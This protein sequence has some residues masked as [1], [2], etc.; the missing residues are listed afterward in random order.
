M[1]LQ[2]KVQIVKARQ[3]L[4]KYSQTIDPSSCTPL[5]RDVFD[6][7]DDDSMLQ[8][9]AEEKLDHFTKLV[10]NFKESIDLSE[11][12]DPVLNNKLQD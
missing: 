8:Y 7:Y 1:I 11:T 6:N 12:F 3:Y 10:F 5:Q 4:M 2:T 9:N